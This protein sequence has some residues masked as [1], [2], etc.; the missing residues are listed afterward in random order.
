MHH[1]QVQ[2][3]ENKIPLKGKNLQFLSFLLNSKLS[4]AMLEEKENCLMELFNE[5]KKK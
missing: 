4:P 5:L 3:G 2:N 1:L